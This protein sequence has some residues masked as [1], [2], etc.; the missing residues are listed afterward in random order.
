MNFYDWFHE[1]ENYG[2]RAERFYDDLSRAMDDPARM[3]QW[4]KVAYEMG[5]NNTD[6]MDGITRVEVIGP[7]SREYVRYLKNGD[8]TL[9]HS[10]QDGGRTI[11]LFI[12]KK[13]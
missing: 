3:V 2:L 7:E 5:S 4:L 1:I 11:K 8:E 6:T 12:D 10:I 9:S 13:G